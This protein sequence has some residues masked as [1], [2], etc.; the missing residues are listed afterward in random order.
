MI[1]RPAR[2]KHH[3][4]HRLRTRVRAA[5]IVSRRGIAGHGPIA[6]GLALIGAAVYLFDR[7]ITT[8]AE[9]ATYR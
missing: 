5:A 9:A 4:P 7:Y 2:H 3:C 8:Q 1:Y 6:V